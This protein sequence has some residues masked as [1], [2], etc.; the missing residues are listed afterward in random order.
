VFA[1]Q[2]INDCK[3]YDQCLQLKWSVFATEIINVCNSNDAVIN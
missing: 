3:S 1:T 2:T